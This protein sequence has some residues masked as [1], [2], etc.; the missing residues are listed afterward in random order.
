LL[1]ILNS[2][3]VDNWIRPHVTSNI[4]EALLASIRIPEIGLSAEDERFLAHGALRLVSNHEAFLPLWHGEL[5][6]KALAT[7]A[8][9]FPV[10]GAV[11]A[12]LELRAAIDAVIAHL[13][14]FGRERY[15]AVLDRFRHKKAPET[16]GLCLARFQ[17]VESI[18]LEAF[19]KRYDPFWAIPLN[20]NLPKRVIEL[21]PSEAAPRETD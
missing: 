1:A 6:G 21:R 15:G 5:D 9:E 12:R 19:R 18:G 11:Q 14:G 4:N 10:L 16:R 8:P 20:E 7:S 2:F 13:F 3:C 17:E